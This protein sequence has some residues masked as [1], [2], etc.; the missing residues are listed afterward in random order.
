MKPGLA[1]ELPAAVV[2]GLSPTGLHV[3][4]ELGRAGV[5][6]TGVCR[7]LQPG[8]ASRYLA[9]CIREPDRARLLERLLQRFPRRGPAARPVL[10][11]CSDEDVEFVQENAAA[12]AAHFAFQASY[13][14][15]LAGRIMTKETFYAL[16]DR[17]AVPYP[18]FWRALPGEL[19]A[20]RDRISY[21]CMIKP[22]RIHDI[23]AKMRGRKGWTARDPAEFDRVLD[24][25]PPD[26]GV[27]LVQEI[28]AGAE[29]EITLY[30]AHIGDDGQPRE[31]FTGRKLR[32]YP[33]GFGSASL[34]QSAP[35]EESRALARDVLA[36]VG[37][38]G[39]AAVE[40]KRDAA[41]GLLKI[42]EI[43][44]RPSLWFSITS[45]AGVHPVLAAYRALAGEAA[46]PGQA[47]AQGVRWRYALKDAWSA[48]FYRLSRGFVLPAPDLQAVGAPR[49]R[50]HALWAADDPAPV[51]TECLLFV[52]KFCRRIWR[53]VLGR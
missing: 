24:R 45:A 47:Q 9:D 53:T 49:L 29:S 12:L 48:A 37:Y 52:V 43:N 14:D 25:I 1:K 11:P 46:L 21:P 36:A 42:I 6:V 44:V 22:S 20:L 51:A 33:P 13:A 18:R 10:I 50:T 38:R 27:L 8:T 16:C 23:K 17:H 30:C 31:E 5:R 2:M 39:I 19:K 40:F 4:R 34:V 26:A 28:V 35:E 7:E 32:Q 3:V 15:G 41:S